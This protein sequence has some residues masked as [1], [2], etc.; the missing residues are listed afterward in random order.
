MKNYLL[1]LIMAVLGIFCGRD[2]QAQFVT[3]P[4]ANFVTYL[5]TNYPTCMNGNQMDTTCV[6]II[7]ET[8]VNCLNKS[9]SDLSGIEYFDNLDTLI[10][11]NNN[12]TS[13]A[14]LPSTV[15]NLIC[16]NN[17]F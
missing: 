9:I 12:L 8:K 11:G 4:D 10:C 14:N 6:A 5:Q 3:I 1:T 15:T 16:Y 7:S 2:M 17:N 13:L